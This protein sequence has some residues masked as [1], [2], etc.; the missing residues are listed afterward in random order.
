M[1]KSTEKK[2]KKN[3]NNPDPLKKKPVII[4][5]RVSQEDYEFLDAKKKEAGYRNMSKYVRDRLIKGRVSIVRLSDHALVVRE[6]IQ[7]ISVKIGK[8]GRNYNQVVHSINSIASKMESNGVIATERPAIYQMRKLEEQTKKLIQIHNEI[9]QKI[10]E[11]EHNED[12][13]S[14]E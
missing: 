12:G 1:E 11:I 10:E 13:V 8:I 2:F 9:K 4:A 7:E 5:F 6:Q 3:W 14:V